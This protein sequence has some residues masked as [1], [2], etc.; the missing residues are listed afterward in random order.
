MV[1]TAW[2]IKDW[3]DVWED[4]RSR[5]VSRLHWI[6]FKL[7]RNSEAYPLL[8]SSRQGVAA[9][10]VFWAL[11]LVAARCPVRG[12]LADERGPMTTARLAARTRISAE[13]IEEAVAVLAGPEI[14][15]LYK[16]E[17]STYGA[18]M[19]VHLRTDGAPTEP[20]QTTDGEG[21]D[22]D[23]ARPRD[24][25]THETATA[26]ARRTERAPS[27]PVRHAAAAAELSP[28][29][30]EARAQYLLRK[31]E[32]L[33]GKGWITRERA[34]ELASLPIDQEDVDWVLREAK[35]SRAT[36][37]NPAGY[38]VKQLRKIGET[39]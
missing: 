19:K 10:G 37:A 25:T 7:D 4:Y 9:Y 38:V 34:I 5:E 11:V 1:P 39:E 23:I 26:T 28:Q 36:L 31:P 32:W 35:A 18:P 21:S 27:D 14:G 13:L 16:S 22:G 12:V 30:L 3:N 2:A 29:D 6:K 33:N 17:V 8:V 15:W 20:P 24:K